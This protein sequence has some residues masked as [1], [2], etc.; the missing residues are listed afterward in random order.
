M[1]AAHDEPVVRVSRSLRVVGLVGAALG[2]AFVVGSTL[3][4]ARD[5]GFSF[6]TTYLSDVGNAPGWPQVVFNSGMLLSA[7]LR[8]VFLVFL[9][10]RLVH[11]GAGVSFGRAALI[12][13]ALVVV[14]S[15]GTAAVPFSFNLRIHKLS[16]LVYFFGT[17]ALQ[18]LIAVQEIRLRLPRVLPISTLALVAIYLVFACLLAMVGRVAG[19]TRA[20]PVIWEWL[21]FAA[22]MVW[23]IA[24]SLVLG[25]GRRQSLQ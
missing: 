8:Y 17:V 13:G 18:S 19:I 11:Q 3:L 21:A 12:I 23:L 5:H 7:P 1:L 10:F 20:T 2:V 9:V 22:I 6:F 25:T 15:I 4:Y 24:H 16:A 14:G